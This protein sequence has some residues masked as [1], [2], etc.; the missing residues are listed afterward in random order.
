[1][2]T[3]NLVSLAVAALVV[4]L[5][6]VLCL[7]GVQLGKYI[8]IPA[9]D[10]ITRGNEFA[11]SA[12]VVLNVNE[13][14]AAEE[15]EEAEKTP[16]SE[17]LYAKAVEIMKTRASMLNLKGVYVMEQGDSR[18]RLELPTENVDDASNVLYTLTQPCHIY[19][20]NPAG[21][22]VL[23]GEDIVSSAMNADST[24][25]VYYVSMKVEDGA[26]TEWANMTDDVNET[27]S[28]YVDGA[29][30]GSAPASQLLSTGLSFNNLNM[31]SNFAMAL[32]TGHI[33]ASLEAAGSGT[34]P[35]AMTEA[36]FD[37]GMF[38]LA[39]LVAIAAI[40]MII[41]FKGMGVVSALSVVLSAVAVVYIYGLIPYLTFAAASFFG[42]TAAI[43]VKV[44]CD[45]HLLGKVKGLLPEKDMTG[46]EAV[47]LA[48]HE[49]GLYALEVSAVAII[50]ALVAQYFGS[51]AVSGF[52]TVFAIGSFVALVVTVLFT[53]PL[54]T[55]VV[56]KAGKLTD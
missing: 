12:Y 10:G 36:N 26:L 3:K 39:V 25:T 42:F 47:R 33:E 38:A 35:A 18:I 45:L 17:E 15:G 32:Q 16:A 48:W 20:T 49:S 29:L 55:C 21:E 1:M 27:T 24:G 40:V 34:I 19:F 28:V 13:P 50:V 53:R 54:V 2:K 56:D 22:V 9:A 31:A 43:G 30:L 6:T 46:A 4:V 37:A 11:T 7:T 8:V 52:T 44:L 5:L 23:E 51:A 14:I 41:V